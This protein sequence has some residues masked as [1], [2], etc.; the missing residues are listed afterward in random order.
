MKTTRAIALAGAVALAAT[1]TTVSDAGRP[2]VADPLL[3]L[4]DVPGFGVTD[5]AVLRDDLIA[6]WESHERAQLRADCMQQAGFDV[7]PQVTY[8][9]Q[10]AMTVAAN[11]E[12]LGV[13]LPPATAWQGPDPLFGA[14]EHNADLLDSFDDAQLDAYFRA[15]NGENLET[16]R[17]VDEAHAHH[18]EAVLE[19]IDM[20]NY[21]TGGCARVAS[22]AVPSIWDAKRE[23][24]PDV[25]LL[26]TGGRDTETF[27][28]YQQ[29]FEQ[30][31]DDAT[32][33][34]Y[35]SPGDAERFTQT[36]GDDGEALVV[37][38]ALDDCDHHWEEGSLVAATAAAD[39]LFAAWEPLLE[40]QRHTYRDALVH[41]AADVEFLTWLAALPSPLELEH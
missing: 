17:T 19:G 21:A 4:D 16:V 9:S 23:I 25:L 13:Q 18:D 28:A 12:T 35:A 5:D 1:I 41:I 37:L 14:E 29:A 26:R 15:W 22:D 34:A 27:A 39:D 31:M 8:P 11:A 7:Q 38:A 6:L 36:T 40:Q 24:G 33:T 32:G 3:L 30:C 10:P 20:E 2:A